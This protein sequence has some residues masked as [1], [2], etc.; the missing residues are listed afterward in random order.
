MEAIQGMSSRER[1]G[2]SKKSSI[3]NIDN[4]NQSSY[5]ENRANS[6]VNFEIYSRQDNNKMW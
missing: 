4:T 2:S 6:M 3:A 1:I 5:C